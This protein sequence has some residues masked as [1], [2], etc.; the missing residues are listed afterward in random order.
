M[1]GKN[2][3]PIWKTTKLSNKDLFQF[4]NGI[5]T[6]KKPPFINCKVIRNTNF[7]NSGF[8]D[9][10]DVAVIPIEERYLEQKKLCY[11]DIIIE[12]SGGG[13]QQP[14]G[15]VV[16]FNQYDEDY[17]FS[18]FTSRLRIM[19]SSKITPFF[20]HYYLLYFYK[21]G[22]T[23]IMQKRTTGIRNLT[24]DKYKDIEVPLPPLAEQELIVSVLMK[25]QRCKLYKEKELRLSHE[26]KKEMMEYYFSDESKCV[27]TKRIGE[28]ASITSG[29]TPKRNVPEYWNGDIPWVKTGEINYNIINET[30]ERITKLGLD[31]SSAKIIPAGTLLMAMYGQGITRG[32]VALLGVD[33]AINQACAAIKV[34]KDIMTEYLYYFLTFNYEK[35][36]SLGHGA[37]QK[38][39][40]AALVKSIEVPIQEKKVQMEIVYALQVCDKKINILRKELDLLDEMFDTML[41]E[42][43]TG[44]RPVIS[45]IEQGVNG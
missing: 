4:E 8:V 15:R 12:R 14:V 13:P 21:A 11:G 18:N 30:E 19:D 25:L 39:L 28:M 2:Y 32:R 35:I 26:F 24:F 16:I 10:S 45:L 44:K 43:M 40:N 41:E 33:A 17:S 42:L 34:N 31:N 29:G 9:L 20:L 23:E 36:R 6:G 38:N 1:K 37:N 27:K 22:N 5:W 7:T 3:S